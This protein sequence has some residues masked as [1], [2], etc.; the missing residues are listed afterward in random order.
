MAKNERN[1]CSF[2]VKDE[3]KAVEENIEGGDWC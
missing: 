3:E 2:V 1:L